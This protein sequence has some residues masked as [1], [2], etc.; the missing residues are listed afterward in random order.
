MNQITDRNTKLFNTPLELGL[1]TLFI[2]TRFYPENLSI[3]SIIYLDY[4]AIH[5]SDIKEG[6]KSLHPKYPFRSSELVVK[7]EILQKS[8]AFLVSKELVEIKLTNEGIYYASTDIGR[9]LI[10]LFESNYSKQLVSVCDW[11][12]ERFSNLTEEDMAQIVSI[13]IE[14]WGGEFSNES[15]FRGYS[16]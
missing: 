12:Y 7:R 10:S 16:K 14:K 1:R 4:F 3:E 15:K 2:M 5:S 9:H 6:P 11:L 13:N 8:M